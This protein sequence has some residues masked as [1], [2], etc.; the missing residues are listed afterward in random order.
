MSSCP[1]SMGGCNTQ[2]LMYQQPY[3]PHGPSRMFQNYR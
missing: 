2:L 1:C 3:P